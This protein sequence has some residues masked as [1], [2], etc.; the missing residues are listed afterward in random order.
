MSLPM[1]IAGAE[2]GFT[3]VQ[4]HPHLDCEPTDRFFQAALRGEC[5]IHRVDGFFESTV[6]TIACG[7]DNDSAIRFDRITQEGVVPR[8][9]ILHQFR[10]LLPEL[11]AAFDIGKKKGHGPKRQSTHK[12]SLLVSNPF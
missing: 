8:Q 9:R 10:V 11:R 4:A 3:A 1:V 2:L 7:L 12:N 5:C 6:D